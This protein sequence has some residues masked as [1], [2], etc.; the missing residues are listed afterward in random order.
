MRWGS[1]GSASGFVAEP[2]GPK[3]EHV[4]RLK[5]IDAEPPGR[6]V[7]RGGGS[8]VRWAEFATQLR[9]EPL[10]WAELKDAETRASL[11]KQAERIRGGVGKCWSPAGSFESTVRRDGGRFVL[12]ARF[13]G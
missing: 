2:T 3:I 5:F 7:R 12:Y 13:K 8:Y 1:M 11:D 4:E 10:R 9:T 6:P